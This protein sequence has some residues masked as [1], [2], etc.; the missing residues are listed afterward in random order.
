MVHMLSSHNT[1]RVNGSKVALFLT[2]LALSLTAYAGELTVGE[3]APDFKAVDQD[4]TSWALQKHLGGK[5]IVVYFYPAA[6]TG[7]CTKQACSYRDHIKQVGDLP[8][9]VI[10]ISGDTPQNLN[11]FRQAEGLNFTLLSDPQG[12]I[13][14]AFGVPVKGGEKSITRTVGGK[15][16]ELNRSSTPAR[17]TFIIDP[18]GSI[19]YKNPQVNAAQDLDDVLLF[20][21]NKDH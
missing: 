11:Y 14:K 12:D 19:V 17:W 1:K 20:L 3:K 9:E 7:G 18:S 8:F 21:T 15:E 4:G 13:A 2:T 5:Y 6:M 10:G 16:V